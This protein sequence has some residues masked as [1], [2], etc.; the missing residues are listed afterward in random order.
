MFTTVEFFM[1]RWLFRASHFIII[2]CIALLYIAVNFTVTKISGV[3]IYSVMTWEDPKTSLII[4]V[5]LSLLLAVSF[6]LFYYLAKIMQ[7]QDQINELN[8]VSYN[9]SAVQNQCQYF[10]IS[11]KEIAVPKEHIQ[12]SCIQT[13]IAKSDGKLDNPIAYSIVI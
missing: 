4:C 11:D 1:Q 13:P 3:P 7:L 6:F 8:K 9:S 12:Y 5:G 2:L 10:L